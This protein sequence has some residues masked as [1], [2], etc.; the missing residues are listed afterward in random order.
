MS[1]A[2]GQEKNSNSHWP[3]LFFISFMLHESPQQ[4]HSCLSE[5]IFMV[6]P[7]VF[8]ALSFISHESPQQQQ[9]SLSDDVV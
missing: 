2:L 3:L 8:A 7:S 6:A 5:D 1:A 9:P 4:Q